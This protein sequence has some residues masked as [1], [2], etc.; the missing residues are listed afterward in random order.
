MICAPAVPTFLFAGLALTLLAIC[1]LLSKGD[2][3]WFR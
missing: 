3:Q 2:D 1:L